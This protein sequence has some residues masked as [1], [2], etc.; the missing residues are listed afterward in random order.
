[1]KALLVLLLLGSTAAAAPWDVR[2]PDEVSAV[3]GEVVAVS[4]TISPGA[5]RT[6]ST[7]GPI[8]I[9][10]RSETLTL[11]RRRYG[12]K[13]AEDP[14]AEAP[15]FELRLTA[16]TAG[17]HELTVEVRAWVCRK[18]TCAPVHETRTVT[19]RAAPVTP[20]PAPTP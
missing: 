7:A 17:D 2:M 10:L 12:R 4:V 11:P 3:P 14:G 13:Q 16:P 15:R 5:G 9:S 18:K 8:R 19:V 20:P 1:M 6:I